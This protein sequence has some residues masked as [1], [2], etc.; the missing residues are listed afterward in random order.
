MKIG[1][2]QP[3]FFPYLGYWQLLGYVDQYVVYDDV[4]Y[5]KGGW[6][7][8]NNILLNGEKHL[9]T[10]PLDNPSSFR[11]INEIDIC[12]NSVVRNKIIKTIESAYR[13]APKYAV[14]MP[15]IEQLIMHSSG[16]SE[17]NVET[18]SWVCE[19]LGIATK[20]ILS[21][22]FSKNNDLKGQDKVMDIVKL[23]EGDTYVNSIGGIFTYR[24]G[25]ADF[26]TSSLT[27]HL[28]Q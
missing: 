21:S 16:I 28:L 4:N 11:K 5:I 20:I 22:E 13:K 18:I 2:M 25:K 12:H 3:Y 24:T 27:E 23:L 19:Y 15:E 7:N 8:R 9:L 26:K 17:L 10:L 6:I 14:I 1:I